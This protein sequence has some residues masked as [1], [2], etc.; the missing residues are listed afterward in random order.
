MTGTVTPIDA[1]AAAPRMDQRFAVSAVYVAA[2]FLSIMDV[3]IVNVAIPT[4]GRDFHS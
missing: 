1:V 3:T 4:I 2:L